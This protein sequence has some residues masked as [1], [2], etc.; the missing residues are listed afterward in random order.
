MAEVVDSGV[1][2]LRFDLVPE[3]A[4]LAASTAL[5]VV[6]VILVKRSKPIWTP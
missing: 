4:D 5:D 3:A 1:E 2:G 6:D